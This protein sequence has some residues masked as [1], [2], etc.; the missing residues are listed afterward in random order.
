MTTVNISDAKAKLSKL[1]KAIES[2]I[3]D[4]IIIARNGKP[5]AK[6]VPIAP[7]RAPRRLGLLEGQYRSFSLE[8]FNADDEEIA[9]MFLHGPIFPDEPD[10]K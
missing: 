5:A 10:A 3:E 9:R 1:V 6:L 8:E 2:G 7:K 4:E